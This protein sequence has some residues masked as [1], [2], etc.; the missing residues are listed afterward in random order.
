MNSSNTPNATSSRESECGATHLDKPDGRTIDLCGQALVPANPSARRVKGKARKTKDI[1]G[2][3]GLDLSASANLSRSL[4]SK[5]RLQ[6]D[7]VGSTLYK[8]TWKES[9]T[10]LGRLVSRLVAS[11]LRTSDKDFTSWPT[12]TAKG[13]TTGGGQVKDAMEKVRPSG[14]TKGKLLKNYAMLA[15]ASW[16]TPQSFDASNNGAPRPL[17]YKGNAPSEQGNTRD[18]NKAGSYRGD[19]KDYAGLATWVTPQRKSFRCG[20]AKRFL[21]KKHAVSLNDQAM[22]APWNSPSA[23]DYKG[24]YTGGAE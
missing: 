14:C 8:L 11:V 12:P 21:E 18:P 17:R 19:L 5:L 4:A 2:Q 3:H 6:S 1:S 20:Q 23:T 24:G 15:L 9:V 7:R 16:P 10:P 22:L 13:D